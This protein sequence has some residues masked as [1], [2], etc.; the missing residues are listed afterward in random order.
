MGRSMLSHLQ[1]CSIGLHLR[2][3]KRTSLICHDYHMPV[4]QTELPHVLKQKRY[5]GM[6]SQCHKPHVEYC[7]NILT[8][9]GNFPYYISS[10][11]IVTN[12]VLTVNVDITAYHHAI[13]PYTA[14]FGK[15]GY[16]IRNR[17]VLSYRWLKSGSLQ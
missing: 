15:I 8:C 6:L 2:L 9:L 17:T 5:T 10:N 11:M 12:F 7:V 4:L 13:S 1:A 14:L 3:R 16:L